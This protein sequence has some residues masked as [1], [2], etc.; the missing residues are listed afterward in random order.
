MKFFSITSKFG[1]AACAIAA[2]FVCSANAQ[3]SIDNA[4]TRSTVPG[5][6]ATG[7]FMTIASEKPL[8]L[9]KASSTLIKNVE[10][11]E[12]KMDAGVMKMREVKAIDVVPGKVT[13]LKPGG[14]HIMLMGLEAPLVAGS[15]VPLTLTFKDKNNVETKV[16]IDADVRELSR[17]MPK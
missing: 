6:N 8:A 5:Q 3:I 11:H 13:E 17:S 10:V 14:Y 1:F 16:N 2:V 7:A 9:V 4:W 15:K 12:M